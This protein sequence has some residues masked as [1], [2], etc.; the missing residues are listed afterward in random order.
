MKPAEL[1]E[2]IDAHHEWLL[3]RESGRSFPLFGN[4]IDVSAADERVSVGFLDDVGFHSWRLNEF[5][6][7]DGAIELDVAG[8]FA[9][10]RELLRIVPRESA[11]ALAAAIELA[12][13]EK[14]NE[15][16][17]LI[18]SAPSPAKLVRVALNAENGRLAQ[19]VGPIG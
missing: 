12:R 17:R 14:A 4:E 15:I 9:R 7:N 1:R 6:F 2:L 5:K 3:I 16:A 13:L 11:A 10:K 8:A 18:E 19:I